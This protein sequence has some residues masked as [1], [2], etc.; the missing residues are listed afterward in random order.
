MGKSN[1]FWTSIVNI[2]LVNLLWN[3]HGTDNVAH[4]DKSVFLRSNNNKGKTMHKRLSLLSIL[5]ITLSLNACGPSYITKNEYVPPAN[6]AASSCLQ[7]CEIKQSQC[8]NTCNTKN[9]ICKNNAAAKARQTLPTALTEYTQKLEIY[10]VEQERYF[11]EKRERKSE[12]KRLEM[13]YDVYRD[14]CAKDSYYCDRKK[15]IKREL[16]SLKYSSVSSPDRPEKPTLASE[17]LRHQASCTTACGCSA[18]YDSCYTSCGGRIIPHKICT[19]N[20]PD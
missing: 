8:Q 15:E 20:C 19:K 14:R 4:E 11:A 7:R 10:T 6:P 3:L 9:Q 13:D 17:T 5:I 16:R 1:D 2:Y 12:I 18:T